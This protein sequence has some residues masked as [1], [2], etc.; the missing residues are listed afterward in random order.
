VCATSTVDHFFSK[1]SE[2]YSGPDSSLRF[3][4]NE[5]ALAVA[6][7]LPSDAYYSSCRLALTPMRNSISLMLAHGRVFTFAMTGRY[8]LHGVCPA[9]HA[10]ACVYPSL[11]DVLV[12][13]RPEEIPVGTGCAPKY[14]DCPGGR[15]LQNGRCM[16]LPF[17]LA[18]T[19]DKSIVVETTKSARGAIGQARVSVKLTE[20]KFEMAWRA[21]CEGIPWLSCGRTNGRLQATSLT[22]DT[23]VLNTNASGFADY[24]VEADKVTIIRFSSRVEGFEH[25]NT[26][27]VGERE[28]IILKMRVVADVQLKQSRIAIVTTDGD[29]NFGASND[30]V[31]RVSAKDIDSLAI[32]RAQ[33]LYAGVVQGDQILYDDRLAQG[34]F[35][36]QM[37]Y[38]ETSHEHSVTLP[39]KLF[40]YA[41]PYTVFV[42]RTRSVLPGG[43][44]VYR[45]IEVKES[46]L[47]HY[48]VIGVVLLGLGALISFLMRIIYKDPERAKSYV[49]SFLSFEFMLFVDIALELWDIVSD[50]LC[51]NTVVGGDQAGITL[52][53]VYTLFFGCSLIASAVAILVK[54]RLLIRKIRNRKAGLRARSGLDR[55]LALVAERRDAQSMEEQ[56]APSYILLALAEDIPMGV[57]SAFFLREVVLV[58][59]SGKQQPPPRWAIILMLVSYATSMLFVGYKVSFLEKLEQIW[60]HGRILALQQHEVV[61]SL[62]RQLQTLTLAKA[63]VSW[64]TLIENRPRTRQPSM[65]TPPKLGS[66]RLRRLTSLSAM[67][68]A[69]AAVRHGRLSSMSVAPCISGALANAGAGAG[70]IHAAGSPSLGSTTVSAEAERIAHWSEERV[71]EWLTETVNLPHLV[72]LFSMHHVDGR[73]LYAMSGIQL[74]GMGVPTSAERNIILAHVS[75]LFGVGALK[76]SFAN[77]L[78]ETAVE[79]E[80]A[81]NGSLAQSGGALDPVREDDPPDEPARAHPQSG[82]LNDRGAGDTAVSHRDSHGIPAQ[83]AA[84]SGVADPDD[85]RTDQA[86]PTASATEQAATGAQPAAT[87]STASRGPPAYAP[88]GTVVTQVGTMLN[89]RLRLEYDSE[90]NTAHLVAMRVARSGTDM[91]FESQSL[92][93]SIASCGADWQF[94]GVGIEPVELAW[95]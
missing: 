54:L 64:H 1:Y 11:K 19:Q 76:R 92:R 58:P 74:V 78:A 38:D 27:F 37:L 2:L 85:A 50:T 91:P 81:S 73:V 55:E 10:D 67:P 59:V 83:H 56:E 53:F 35:S 32:K 18:S 44:A 28:E 84:A 61:K 90:T 26:S 13:C 77:R 3:V 93:E 62:A 7:W 63:F 4:A 22:E 89:T 82:Y 88:D 72:A 46:K 12:K 34:A 40:A 16:K 9:R 6:L 79:A 23:V 5:S 41:Q 29:E 49:I 57:L 86:A 68:C 8:L 36:N 47:V 14:K 24:S 51:L 39:G 33:N 75:K 87:L 25:F 60:E 80:T 66:T 30:V 42:S 17:L 20:G 15:V 94:Q 21:A 69:H 65:V 48:I 43:G 95:I 52:K 31:V 45:T 70:A 71:A